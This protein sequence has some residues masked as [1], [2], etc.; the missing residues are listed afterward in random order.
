MIK[1]NEKKDRLKAYIVKSPL[2]AKFN[3]FIG[4]L[5]RCSIAWQFHPNVHCLRQTTVSL[6]IYRNGTVNNACK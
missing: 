5:R 2:S 1:A 4:T 6:R 3:D